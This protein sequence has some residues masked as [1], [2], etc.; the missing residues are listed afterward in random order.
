MADFKILPRSALGLIGN[1]H[2]AHEGIP[3]TSLRPPSDHEILK[4]IADIDN[5]D[6]TDTR[7]G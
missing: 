6:G 7:S 1:E 2:L 3:T 4:M 5:D